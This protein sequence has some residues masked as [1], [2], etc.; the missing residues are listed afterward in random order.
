MSATQRR[1]WLEGNANSR[2]PLLNA[3][4]RQAFFERKLKEAQETLGRR[5][6]QMFPEE[7]LKGTPYSIDGLSKDANKDVLD[8]Q[9]A[10]VIDLGILAPGSATQVDQNYNKEI[11][12]GSRK[13]Q[14]KKGHLRILDVDV[15]DT[16]LRDTYADSQFIARLVNMMLSDETGSACRYILPA[17]D[18]NELESDRGFTGMHPDIK[19]ADGRP[20]VIAMQPPGSEAQLFG[21]AKLKQITKRASI[22]FDSNIDGIL[23]KYEGGAKIDTAG[24]KGKCCC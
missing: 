13:V 16:N 10:G 12:I 14:V 20:E 5:A 4:R 22:M 9:Q 23:S 15:L 2:Y 21:I 11:S 18:Y 1:Q 19:K 24:Y 17:I 3:I 7:Y 6:G 8:S